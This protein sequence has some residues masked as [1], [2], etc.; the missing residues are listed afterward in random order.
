MRWINKYKLELFL[1]VGVFAVVTLWITIPQIAVNPE[2]SFSNESKNPFEVVNSLFSGLAFALLIYTALMQR[3]E[4]SLQRRELRL[5][6]EELKKSAKAQETLVTL[7]REQLIVQK[8][9]LQAQLKL[10]EVK[11][12]PTINGQFLIDV[13]LTVQNHGLKIIMAE[14]SKEYPDVMVDRFAL[15]R[16]KNIFF[17]ESE[18]I[19]IRLN[20]GEA[21]MPTNLRLDIN[22][23]S[24]D[25]RIFSQ[26][27]IFANN[28][29]YITNP[30]VANLLG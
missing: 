18:E 7:T 2:S 24:L 6:R 16:L 23:E 28:T 12:A 29:Q 13:Y 14:A 20:S 17:N 3:K 11:F 8:N 30:R 19:S 22:F 26:Q 4:L 1:V 9:N 21:L 15:E 27:V 5:T 25:R 10:K